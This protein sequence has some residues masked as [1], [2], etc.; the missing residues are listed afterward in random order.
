M[1]AQSGISKYTWRLGTSAGDSDIIEETEVHTGSEIILPDLQSVTG[2]T[3]PV[4]QRLFSTVRAYNK[5]GK[6]NC[7]EVDLFFHLMLLLY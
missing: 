7:C 5:A 1:D 3:L 6:S 4:G 2:Q